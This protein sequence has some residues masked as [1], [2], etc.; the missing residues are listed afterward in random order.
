M[1]GVTPSK[2][3]CLK[4]VCRLDSL[5]AGIRMADLAGELGV[6]R[7]RAARTVAELEQA[8]YVECFGKARVA[9]TPKG[10]SCAGAVRSRHQLIRL[11]FLEI[12]QVDHHTAEREA[13]ALESVLSDASLAAMRRAVDSHDDWAELAALI[14][15]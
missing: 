15:A 2:Q 1:F 12:L 9:A 4:A 13:G 11:Y 7:A 14:P 3:D 6:T 8:G 10:R 5:G